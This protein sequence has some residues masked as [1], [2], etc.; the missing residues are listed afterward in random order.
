V[1]YRVYTPPGYST[2]T[3]RYPVLYVQDG[4]LAFGSGMAYDLAATTL[5]NAGVIL[6]LVIVAIDE[7]AALKSSEYNPAD[8]GPAYLH[9]LKYELKPV[10]DAA[11]R[12]DALD[13]SIGGWSMGGGVSLEAIL[14]DTVSRFHRVFALS[15]PVLVMVPKF[16]ALPG[17]LPVKIFWYRGGSEG[18][19]ALLDA[20]TTIRTA[21][22]SK[23]WIDGVDYTYATVPT[24]QHNISA[25]SAQTDALL[26][27]LFPT[28]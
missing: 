4:T 3:Q 1:A 2:G 21:L 8:R 19:Q 9:M 14:E 27:F 10:I 22:L 13:N 25:F 24:A 28:P 7:V 12:T 15:P 23:G 26:R 11:Y 17:K 20:D 6:P 5:I 16:Q 18:N